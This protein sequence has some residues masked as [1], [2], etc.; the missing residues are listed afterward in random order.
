MA[1]SPL[2]MAFAKPT[3]QTQNFLRHAMLL[4]K[5]QAS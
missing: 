1:L 4:E 2:M 3:R 5:L